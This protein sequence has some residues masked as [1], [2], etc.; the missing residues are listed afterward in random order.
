M[1]ENV[2][3]LAQAKQLHPATVKRLAEEREAGR[4]EG[5]ELEVARRGEWAGEIARAA[6]L[7][8]IAPMK[9]QFDAAVTELRSFHAQ[10]MREARKGAYWRGFAVGGVVLFAV[11]CGTGYWAWRDAQFV[12]AAG[13]AMER[14][15]GQMAPLPPP[16]VRCPDGA[17]DPDCLPDTVSRD[18]GYA[19]PGREP[20]SAR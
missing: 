1:T 3:N 14:R 4:E 7:A 13:T 8:A 19:R 16:L 20:A 15:G 12:T 17:T 6:A 10:H 9:D 2:T 5:R 11:V 18:S